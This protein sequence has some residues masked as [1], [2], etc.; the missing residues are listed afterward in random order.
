M[1]LAATCTCIPACCSLQ[2]GFI[3]GRDVGQGGC[4]GA[5]QAGQLP[6]LPP[7]ELGSIWANA[8]LPLFDDLQLKAG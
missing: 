3:R 7:R 5:D 6:M 1:H 2:E 8:W 4:E